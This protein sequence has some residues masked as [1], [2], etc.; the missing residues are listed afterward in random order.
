MAEWNGRWRLVGLVAILATAA[1]GLL[2]GLLLAVLVPDH[3]PAIVAHTTAATATV[4]GVVLTYLRTTQTAHRVEEL[5]QT[6]DTVV[7]PLS[8]AGGGSGGKRSPPVDAR[9]PNEARL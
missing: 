5:R 6:I 7:G 8:S 9:G 2:S 1:V 3:A 4:L